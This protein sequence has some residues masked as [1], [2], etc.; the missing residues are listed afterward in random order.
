MNKKKVELL[1]PAGDLEKLKVA[2]LYGADAVYLGGNAFG[3]RA[4]AKNFTIEEMAEGVKF[5]HSHNAKVYV[6]CN[7]FAHNS[8]INN[9]KLVNYLKSLEEINVD[10]VIVAD[11]GV[12]SIVREAVPNME[13]HISTQANTTNYQTAKF[14]KSLGA[15]RVVMARE[16]SFREIKAL[17]DNVED[18]E[19][20]AFVHG[21]MCMAYSGRCLL[22]N[23]FTN[24]DANRG[25]CAQSCRWKYKIVE[26]TRPGEYYPIEEDERGTYIFNSKDLC[27]IQYIPELIESGVFSFKIEGRVKTAYYVGSVIKAYR[28]AIDDYLNDPALYESKK[29]YYLEEVKKSSYRGYTTG[30]FFDKPKEDAQV[31]TSNSYVRTYDFIGIVKEYDNETGFAIIEQRNKFVVGEEIE[32]LT[33]KGKNFSQKVE[34]MYDMDGNRLEEAPHPQQIIKLKVNNPV[35]VFDMMRKESDNPVLPEDI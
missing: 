21:A 13:V 2:I 5:A 15:T 23:Y 25:A 6:T 30:F 31:Y 3:L 35:S 17:S 8:D 16:M 14:W 9:E 33:T 27:M 32:F 1:A 34:E 22:S 18:I 7:I 12:F 29:D 20:E 24:R 4:K 28:E 26:E 11:P 10:G 19:I